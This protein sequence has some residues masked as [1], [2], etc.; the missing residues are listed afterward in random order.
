[1][2]LLK[3]INHKVKSFFYKPAVGVALFMT[4]AIVLAAPDSGIKNPETF[5]QII[6]QFAIMLNQFQNGLLVVLTVLGVVMVAMGLM[7]FHKA[8]ISQG[9]TEAGKHGATKLTIGVLLLILPVLV[10]AFVKG[11]DKKSDVHI[12]SMANAWN[13]ATTGQYPK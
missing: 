1:M 9:Q 6:Q 12:S 8:A 4:P 7:A 2:K 10:T 5:V 13:S 3:S 11:I